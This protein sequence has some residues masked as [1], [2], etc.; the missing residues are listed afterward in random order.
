MNDFLFMSEMKS[1]LRR[2]GTLPEEFKSI[3][4]VSIWAAR[5]SR[6]QHR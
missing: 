3:T 2:I 5:L 6:G 1:P 4:H